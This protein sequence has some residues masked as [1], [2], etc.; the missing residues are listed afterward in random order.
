[1]KLNLESFS[2]PVKKSKEKHSH[3]DIEKEFEIASRRGF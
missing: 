2:K 3:E 1:M